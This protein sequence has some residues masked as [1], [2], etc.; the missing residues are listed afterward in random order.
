[1]DTLG[2]I[3]VW[4]VLGACAAVWVL[5]AAIMFCKAY[6][7]ARRWNEMR[8]LKKRIRRLCK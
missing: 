6:A 3:A 5:V 4:A 7:A 2:F 8:L 1:M